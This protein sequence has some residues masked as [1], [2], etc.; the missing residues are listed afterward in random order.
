MNE[1]YLTAAIAAAK[2]AGLVLQEYRS[3]FST[4]EKAPRDLVTD[5]DLAAQ[6]TIEQLFKDQ[7]PDHAF[8]GEEST[9]AVRQ[10]AQASG[11]LLWVVDPLDGTANYVHG[12]SMYAV[13]IALVRG[14]EVQVG[15]VH[16]PV[17]GDTFTAMKDGPALNNGQPIKSSRCVSLDYAMIAASFPAG[18]RRDDPEVEQFLRVLVRSQSVR[19]LGSAALNLCYVAQGCLDAY[20]ASNVQAWDVAAGVLIAERA[21]AQCRDVSGNSFDLWQPKPLVAATPALTAEL[22]KCIHE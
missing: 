20:W 21:G 14:D 11:K 6:H 17:S 4:R 16:D 22:L 15:V 10:A 5:A 8:L 9:L 3:K 12:L 2:S 1:T 18:V 13:S 19:R 7:F